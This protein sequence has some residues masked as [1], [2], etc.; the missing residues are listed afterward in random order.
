M[1]TLDTVQR[2]M[3]TVLMHPGGVE[4]GIASAAARELI[5]V[6]PE[7][8]ESVVT[9]SQSLT[10]LERLAIYNHAYFARLL[11][12]LRESYGVVQ[13]CVGEEAFDEFAVNY[14][15]TY[16]S[17]SYTLNDLGANFPQYLRESIPESELD[18][19][20]P[21]F[22]IDLATLERT[23]CEV[24]DGP[25]IEGQA[26]LNPESFQALSP[27][28]WED[29]RLV[30]VPCLRLLELQFPIHE[31]YSEVKRESQ[32]EMPDPGRT[33]LA[34]TRQD[35]VIRRFELTQAQFIV[36]SALQNGESVGEAIYQGGEAIEDL[37]EYGRNL[38]LWF[39]DWTAESLF[40]EISMD[41]ASGLRPSS[42]TQETA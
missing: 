31:Y 12:C 26:L 7:R 38:R 15:Q 17:R 41:A 3:Q 32:A 6:T 39:H 30:T 29:A 37:A 35:F 42:D 25:G 4:Q 1:A 10:G 9:P 21:N 27:E 11:E 18:E 24:F 19:L 34:I 14:L 2:W 5:D 20:W 40:Q 23:Y 33:F 22:V 36:L 16:P 13:K 28:S 8:A